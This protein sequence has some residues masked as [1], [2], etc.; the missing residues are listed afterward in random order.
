MSGDRVGGQRQAA[1]LLHALGE[2][3][4]A[5]MLAAL[6]QQQRDTLQLLLAEL[7]ELGIP[8]D[9]GLLAPLSAEETSSPLH[10]LD[11]AA[12]AHVSQL[13]QQEPQRFTSVL[14]AAQPWRAHA[15]RLRSCAP[16]HVQDPAPAAPALE[17][18]VLGAVQRALA[19]RRPASVRRS[20]PGALWTLATRRLRRLG[21]TA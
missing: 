5:W 1:L 12:L 16:T 20:R 7:R 4:R 6:P 13:L 19:A 17:K 9:A 21:G 11:D 10:D 3:D 8:R 18:A 15:Q 2:E 14:L